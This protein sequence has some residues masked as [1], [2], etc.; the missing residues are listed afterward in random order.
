M[1]W[2]RERPCLRSVSFFIVC[3]RA[4]A[5]FKAIVTGTALLRG[6]FSAGVCARARARARLLLCFFLLA[7]LRVTLSPRTRARS[8]EDYKNI[9]QTRHFSWN[10]NNIISW[11]HNVIRKSSR[12]SIEKTDYVY[13]ATKSLEEK[14]YR[15]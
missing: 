2:S 5:A 10:N 9:M 7:L 1:Y 4:A 12:G 8:Q 11:L 14:A 3:S 6:S 13:N 15:S